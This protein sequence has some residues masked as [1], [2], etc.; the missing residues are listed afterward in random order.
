[1]TQ[2]SGQLAS[3]ATYSAIHLRNMSGFC[4]KAG[5]R[6]LQPGGYFMRLACDRDGHVWTSAVDQAR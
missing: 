1:M 5:C 3:E 6:N 4:V 2:Q